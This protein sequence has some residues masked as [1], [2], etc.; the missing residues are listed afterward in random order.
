MWKKY[1]SIILL[2]VLVLIQFKP[3][4]RSN[5]EVTG[6]INPPEEVKRILKTSCYNCHSHE[7]V[8]PWYSYVAP[9]S[10]LVE[11]DVNEAREELNFST[12]NSYT[13]KKKKK[14]IEEIWEEIEED[15]M[16]LWFYE[17]VHPESRLSEKDTEVIKKWT[18]S[19]LSN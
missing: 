10:W 9:V 13:E 8:Y 14:K 2:A 12:W 17:I 19:Y 16:P 18:D 7:T 6:E 15:E 11:H 3:V 4:D 1:L 5:P